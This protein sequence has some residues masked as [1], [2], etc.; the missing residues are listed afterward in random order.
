M[1][2]SKFSHFYDEDLAKKITQT[3]KLNLIKSKLL[4]SDFV[5][6]INDR[7]NKPEVL[8]D[9]IYKK[10][11]YTLTEGYK[12]ALVYNYPP[13]SRPI[14]IDTAISDLNTLATSLF[15]SAFAYKLI[16]VDELDWYVA[17][18]DLE[19]LYVDMLFQEQEDII[20]N[21][22]LSNITDIKLLAR[23]ISSDIEFKI[24]TTPWDDYLK[25]EF[26]NVRLGLN[27]GYLNYFFN[28]TQTEHMFGVIN[29]PVTPQITLVG[30]KNHKDINGAIL[31]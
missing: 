19:L 17:V 31:E 7:K 18:M 4:D 1:R 13:Q 2:H 21:Q 28:K 27:T 30:T 5:K 24:R 22:P 11:L 12:Q 8:Y 29:N 3:G 10:I 23:K 25:S 16:K 6:S 26:V 20:G 9:L 15:D 14:S